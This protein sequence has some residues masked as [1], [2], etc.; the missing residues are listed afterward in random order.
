MYAEG[1][2][3]FDVDGDGKVDL[4]AGNFWFK[5]EGGNRFK[6]IRVGTIGG[7]I[8]A[9]HFDKH[10]QY[11]QIVIGPGDGSGPLKIY[12][13]SG[14]PE[15]P[16]SWRGRDL[17]GRDLIHGHGLDVGDLNGDGN[18]D[19][20][21]GEMAKWTTKPGQDNPAAT[22]WILYGDGKGNFRNTKLETGDDWHEARIADLDGDGRLDILQ[23]PYSWL[24]P[25]VDVWL[26]RGK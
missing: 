18:L 26:N 13:C 22:G 19:I 5:Y 8:R 16:A 2:D 14:D 11:A 15:N 20:L 7:R 9:G 23:K 17:I 6:P 24:A 1:I 3:A 21:A 12:E 25:R 4:L 10:D